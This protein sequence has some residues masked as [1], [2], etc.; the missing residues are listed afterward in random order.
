MPGFHSRR[1]NRNRHLIVLSLLASTLAFG[2]Q[3]APAVPDEIAYIALYH[4]IYD[5]PKPHWDRETCI[6]WLQEN[7]IEPLTAQY[8]IGT[9]SAYMKKHAEIETQLAAFNQTTGKSLA[10][11]VQQ[12]RQEME[13]R[14]YAELRRL[15]EE[16][17][18]KLEPSARQR[19]GQLLLAVKANIKMKTGGAQ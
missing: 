3:A 6:Q 15:N 13:A 1:S 7:G 16:M 14:R 19:I 11:A 2:Q 9:A 10:P 5:A 17:I 12:Q 8:L 18:S 4:V